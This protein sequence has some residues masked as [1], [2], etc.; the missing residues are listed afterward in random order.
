MKTAYDVVAG[1]SQTLPSVR[2]VAARLG[3]CADTV[4][5]HIKR[6]RLTQIKLSPRCVR[7]D[8]GSVERMIR[9]GLNG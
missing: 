7:V 3:V 1:Q 5:A 8:P 2:E 9:E 4:R 6:G